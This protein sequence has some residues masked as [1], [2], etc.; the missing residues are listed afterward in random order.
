MHGLR[1]GKPACRVLLST[2]SGLSCQF[3]PSE[4]HA[5][6]TANMPAHV[7]L[8]GMRKKSCLVCCACCP[9]VYTY[10]F[11]ANIAGIYWWH[12]TMANQTAAG[13]WGPLV[14]TSPAEPEYS[15]DSVVAVSDW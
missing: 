12:S 6:L 5:G 10:S 15:G 2:C 8:C 4:R 7:G 13:L 11:I 9:G 14:I 1:L 3:P